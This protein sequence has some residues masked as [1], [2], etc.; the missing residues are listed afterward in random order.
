MHGAT[1]AGVVQGDPLKPLCPALSLSHLTAGLDAD[2]RAPGIT[3]S[4]SV[5]DAQ[6]G[7]DS[8]HSGITESL[9]NEDAF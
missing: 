1:Q 5:M 9:R 7:S 3:S 4:A 8:H 2:F 6:Q